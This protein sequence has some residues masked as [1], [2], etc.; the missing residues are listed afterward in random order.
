M[1]DMQYNILV[2]IIYNY[3]IIM[4]IVRFVR[5]DKHDGTYIIALHIKIKKLFAVKKNRSKAAFL[6][7]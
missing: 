6:L 4:Y 1:A 5:R 7:R 2:Y 3:I